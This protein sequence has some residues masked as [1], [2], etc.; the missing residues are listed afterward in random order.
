MK[1]IPTLLLAVWLPAAAAQEIR[2]WTSASGKTLEAAFLELKSD[3]VILQRPGGEQMRIR[4]N[5]LSSADQIYVGSRTRPGPP[6]A[7][8]G[9]TI[10]ASAKLRKLFGPRL[11][12]AQG[13][14]VSIDRLARKK[15][16]VY[17]SASWCGPC[18]MFTPLL[19]DAYRQLQSAGKPFEVVLVSLDKSAADMQAYMTS[20]A[21]PWLAMPFDPER[22]AELV[23]AYGAHGIPKLVVLGAK[24]QTLS[25]EARGEITQHGAQAFDRW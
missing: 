15:I 8:P 18:R 7:A 12:D 5:L 3:Q 22:S 23:T 1:R 11:V 24:G 13:Q 19:I 17:L 4:L 9:A 16:G 10:Q 20:H 21:M 2:T 14:E 25:T 6:R